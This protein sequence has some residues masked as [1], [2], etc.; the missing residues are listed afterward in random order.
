MRPQDAGEKITVKFDQQIMFPILIVFELIGLSLM[1]LI[2]LSLMDKRNY[3]G[4]NMSLEIGLMYRPT[5]GPTDLEID[6]FLCKRLVS[7][8]ILQ[9]P[10]PRINSPSPSFV[11][12]VVVVVVVFV[13]VVL[14]QPLLVFSPSML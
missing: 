9:V 5:D 8:G 11:V 13:P 12:V 7:S 10:L 2:G 14:M 6:N 1:G 4:F 3:N